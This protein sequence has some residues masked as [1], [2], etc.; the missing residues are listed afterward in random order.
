[1]STATTITGRAP[2]TIAAHARIAHRSNPSTE[3]SSSR[4]SQWIPTPLPIS[5]HLVLCSSVASRKEENRSNGREIS[6]TSDNWIR[7]FSA[8]N[9]TPVASALR[10]LTAEVFMPLVHEQV[11]ILLDDLSE[12]PQLGCIITDGFRQ[13]SYRTPTALSTRGRPCRCLPCS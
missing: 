5:L 4:S 11:S 7:K 1:M 8:S 13:G 2:I 3:M 12:F 6:R 9:R 10:A